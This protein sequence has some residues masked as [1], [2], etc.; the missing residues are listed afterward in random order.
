MHLYIFSFLSFLITCILLNCAKNINFFNKYLKTNDEF[1][2]TSKK[3]LYTSISAIRGVGI[4]FLVTFI[5]LTLII[6]IDHDIET[7]N[8][9]FFF[10][11]ALA[12]LSILSFYDD[13]RSIDPR[14]RLVLHLICVYIA[15]STLQLNLVPLPFKV[16]I[17][18][19]IVIWVYLI[20]VTNFIDGS[21][22]FCTINVI[23]FYVGVLILSTSYQLYS[24]YIAI[25]LLPIL[26]AFLIFNMPNAKLFMG[27]SG[28]I[29]LGFLLGY[30]F[31]EIAILINPFYS[32]ILFIYPLA[33]CSIT[34]FKKCI[35]KGHAPWAR[36]GDY[37]FLGPKKRISANKRK[38]VSLMILKVIISFSILNLVLFYLEIKFK[39][40]YLFIINLFSTLLV[41][42][43]YENNLFTKN[44]NRK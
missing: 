19:A 2:F 4:F 14:L 35:L 20:N 41:L 11:L 9:F 36:H 5:L 10:L 43:I 6:T 3:K 22:G 28:S 18:F 29:F 38:K 42:W 15:T 31:L 8:R 44:Y 26:F 17:L 7:P 25:I 13:F 16:S 12:I 33:D 23:S 40:N 21:D 39:N 32:I 37:Y 30:S 27:D 1:V 24:F 34:L